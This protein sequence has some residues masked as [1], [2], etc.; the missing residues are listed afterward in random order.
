MTEWDQWPRVTILLLTYEDGQRRTALP[1]LRAA[2]DHIRYPGPLNLHIADDG[3]V[4]GHVEAL[5]RLAGGYPGVGTIGHTDAARRGY[6]ASYNLATQAFHPTADV[7]LVLEDDWVLQ[8]DLDLSPLVD[9]L[10]ESHPYI[11]C[12]R[13]GYLGFTQEL[14]A[15]RIEATSAGPMVLLDSESEEPHVAAGHPRLELVEHQQEIGPWPEGI[16]PGATEWEWCR[17]EAARRGVVWPLDYGPASMRADSLF[18][19]T[20]AHA[21]GE[22]E[23]ER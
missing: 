14:R 4:P 19:H 2:L 16:A 17:R 3:S 7:V 9:T 23:P 20:G 1:T 12:I 15:I 21:L 8:R 5:R 22:L 13:L 6:G 18:V 11:A 10:Y